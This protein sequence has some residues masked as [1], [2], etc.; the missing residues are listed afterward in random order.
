MATEKQ[1]AFYRSLR[2]QGAQQA[3]SNVTDWLCRLS[4]DEVRQRITTKVTEITE[5]ELARKGVPGMR[6]DNEQTDRPGPG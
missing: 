1:S 3:Y 5:R 4:I 6:S 2:D